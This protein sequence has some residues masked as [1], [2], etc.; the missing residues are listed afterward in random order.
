[1]E[2][3]L[4]MPLL[5]PL[6]S[7][8]PFVECPGS[9]NVAAYFRRYLTIYRNLPFNGFLHAELEVIALYSYEHKGNYTPTKCI[10]RHFD[11]IGT[12]LIRLV[13][14]YRTGINMGV[15]CLKII[16]T[17]Q[18]NKKWGSIKACQIIL[19]EYVFHL[20]VQ[21]NFWVTTL[22]LQFHLHAAPELIIFGENRY[23]RHLKN[24]PNQLNS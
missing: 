7:H 9:C 6:C 8:P 5:R 21:V 13:H 10:G 24:H 17:F 19:I 22:V 4:C 12:P 16:L 11:K 15:N 18:A 23:Y 14:P 1:M 20:G 3:P 2:K